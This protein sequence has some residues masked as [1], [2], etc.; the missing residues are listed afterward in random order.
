[1]KHLI[2][3]LFAGP[4]GW[5]QGLRVL[6]M[7]DREVGIE[8]EVNACATRKAAGFSTVQADVTEID[9][10]NWASCWGLIASPP[11]QS[12]SAAGKQLGFED[13]RGQLVYEVIRWVDAIRPSWVAC[14]QVPRVLPVW[15]LFAQ[16]FRDWGYKTWAGTLQA[17]DFG[18]PQTRE[19]AILMASMKPFAAPTPTHAEHPGTDLFGGATKP[20]VTMAD[21]LGWRE[22]EVINTRG[23]STS[24][25]NEFPVTQPSWAITS[26]TR[27]WYRIPLSLRVGHEGGVHQPTRR[28]LHEPAPTLMFGNDSAQV[29]W[30]GGEE[31]EVEKV[32]EE[33]LWAVTRPSTTVVGSFRPDIV[34]SPGWRTDPK[35]PR[36]NA[37]GSIRVADWEAGVLQSFP[38]D[39]PWQGAK[40]RR[41]QQIGNAVPPKLGAA[42]LKPLIDANA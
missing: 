16:Q 6:G 17:A 4:G 28:G 11:C 41:F 35:E 38:V 37:V 36:Q 42:I 32:P 7:E 29:V 5:T 13:V 14:E 20:W 27:S 1:M 19:R 15:K 34:A 39:Y 30:E 9:P 10:H 18:V 21:A 2:V 31:H 3:D 33:E 8:L 26:K 24:G 25:G 23:A 40:T 22:G 12:F